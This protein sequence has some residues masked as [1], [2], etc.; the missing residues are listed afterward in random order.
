[1]WRA[2]NRRH[3]WC[4][5]AHYRANVNNAAAVRPEAVHRLLRAEDE[6]E[7]IEIEQSVK[8]LFR[9]GFEREEF[10]NTGVVNQY[11]EPAKC[12]LRLGEEAFDV[13][14]FRYVACT[15]T[16]LPPLVVISATTAS[17]PALLEA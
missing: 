13:R 7:N 2:V 9:Y 6:A 3:G 17:A 10:V 11:V 8:M 5:G 15:A 4:R 16:A 1:L 12:L 14:L